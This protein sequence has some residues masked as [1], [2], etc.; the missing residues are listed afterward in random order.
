[1]AK[2]SRAEKAREYRARK[3]AEAGKPPFERK[4]GKTTLERVRAHRE[5]K[6]ETRIDRVAVF[7]IET[8]P[9]DNETMQVVRP[10]FAVLYVGDGS[11]HNKRI[12][13][14][15]F[16]KFV[17]D[18]EM[19]FRSLPGARYDWTIYAHNGGKF[20]W[21]FFMNHL[22]GRANLKG[23]SI[24][25]ARLWGQNIRDSLHIYPYSLKTYAKDD[26][27]YKHM[28]TAA[29]RAKHQ[30]KILD[31]CEADC[32]YTLEIVRKFIK[33]H[34]FKDTIAQ[35]AYCAFKRFHHV[36]RLT[37]SV[38]AKIRP[39]Y[40]GGRVEC[41]AGGGTFE[42]P[43]YYLDVNSMYP[44]V[45][46]NFS[47]PVGQY[48]YW[49]DDGS[50]TERELHNL[51]DYSH[52]LIVSCT[53][54][55]ALLSRTEEGDITSQIIDGVFLTTIWEY[56][57]A[58]KH[59]LI[60]NVKVLGGYY[61]TERSKFTEFV[62]EYYP[63]R[64]QL[65]EKQQQFEEGSPEWREIELERTYIKLI[66][67]SCYGKL[68]QNPERFREYYYTKVGKLPHRSTISED[69][70]KLKFGENYKP[71]PEGW[72]KLADDDPVIMEAIWDSW[73]T[74][75]DYE[76][77]R[78]W[79][80]EWQRQ[81]INFKRYNVGTA[82]SIT[83][84]ARAV[85]LDAICTVR[86][87]IY[88]DTDSVMCRD[89]GVLALDPSELGAWKVEGELERVK[90]AGKKMYFAPRSDKPGAFKMARK[91]AGKLEAEHYE[92]LLN[93]EVVR[94][95]AFGPTLCKD[96]R[97]AYLVRELRMTAGPANTRLLERLAR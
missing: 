79:F 6:R 40:F 41:I 71:L 55:G 58:V 13:Q 24:M 15:D 54:H 96:G 86:D 36:E 32:R 39:F 56:K 25:K 95:V 12:Y 17:E 64:Q 81:V 50:F 69:H 88:C 10:Y 49:V 3:R 22:A 59:N 16:T 19:A 57:V 60:E 20:D 37:Q 4:P 44:S 2:L 87:P 78:A 31:Y 89:P 14:E 93:G 46:R 9:F 43:L 27:K 1:M 83:G 82:A 8:T 35:A 48:V 47:H 75:N 7:D 97:Q 84:A 21:K 18:C 29:S 77:D 66:L 28:A 38:D 51:R 61:T 94:N 45:M 30:K 26:I 92:A 65:S 72:E 76:F 23:S 90:I 85:L 63:K 33:E 62:D 42:G 68:G 5:R 11:P 53:N 67:N 73:L 80:T 70:R 52:F 34:G 91:G 74:R